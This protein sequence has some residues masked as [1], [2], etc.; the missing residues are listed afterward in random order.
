MKYIFPKN[1]SIISLLLTFKRLLIDASCLLYLVALS[2]FTYYKGF[3]NFNFNLNLF[4]RLYHS[5]VNFQLENAQQLK[6]RV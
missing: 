2:T 4:S 6:V 5:N 3:I 1:N